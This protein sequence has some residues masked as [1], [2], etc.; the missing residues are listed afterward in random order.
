MTPAIIITALVSIALAI[1]CLGIAGHAT[2]CLTK[3]QHP[4]GQ[5]QAPKGTKP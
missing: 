4:E 2:I 1:I 3:C 5:S